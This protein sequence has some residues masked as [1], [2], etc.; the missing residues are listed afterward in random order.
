MEKYKKILN[1]NDNK[2]NENIENNIEIK[3]FEENNIIIK[4]K[5]KTGENI[6]FWF[7][8]KKNSK[9][10]ELKDKNYKEFTL[11]DINNENI[12][13]KEINNIFNTTLSFKINDQII[14]YNNINYSEV[15][16][17]RINIDNKNYLDLKIKSYI[18]DNLVRIISFSSNILIKNESEID[19]IINN[20]KNNENIIINNHNSM[21]IPI[22]WILFKDSIKIYVQ[23]NNEKKLLFKNLNNIFNISSYV[24]FENGENLSFDIVEL[25]SN[26]YN[27][28]NIKLYK[29]IIN[30]PISLFNKTPYD[31]KI[32]EFVL[33]SLSNNNLY[34]N[35]NITNSDNV[36]KT[37]LENKLK[38]FYKNNNIIEELIINRYKKSIENNN[39][40]NVSFSNNNGSLICKFLNYSEYNLSV[41]ENKLFKISNYKQNNIK[42]IIFFYYFFCE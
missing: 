8:N 6:L 40:Y 22:N 21:Y 10:F 32:N 39:C 5:N 7:D 35:I 17:H 31:M 18:N 2:E 4:F 23:F 9:Q 14:K 20:D 33:K 1:E 30:S 19:L 38:I 34:K 3:G 12:D 13:Y 29:I 16:F 24:S 15:Q 26:N 41:S 25:E 28:D 27:S 11:E 37:I 42:I 36:I